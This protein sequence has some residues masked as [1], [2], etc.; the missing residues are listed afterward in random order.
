M[1]FDTLPFLIFAGITYIVWRT[2]LGPVTVLCGASILFYLVAGFGDAL[3]IASVVLTN[4]FFSFYVRGRAWVLTTVVALNLANLAYFKYSAFI[5]AGIAGIDGFTGG[6][7]I[8]LGISFYTFQLIA[9]Q[10][11]IAGGRCEQEPN[12]LRFAL[13]VIFFT[14]LIAG[15]IVRAST[16]LPQIRRQWEAQQRRR[17]I[18]S[19]G[20]GLCALGLF[21]KVILSDSL[22]PLVDQ[23]FSLGPA[24]TASAWIGAWLFAFQ[25][26]F[27]FSGYCDIAMGIAYLLGYRLPLNFRQ[28]YLATNPR[29]FWRCWHITLSSWIRDYLY[30]PLG[31]SREGGR[32]RKAVVLI[33]VMSLAGLWHGAGWVFVVWGAFWGV[34]IVLWNTVRAWL[35]NIPVLRWGVN[36]TVVVVLWVFFRSPDITF[37]AAYIFAMFGGDAGGTASFVGG[38]VPLVLLGC[39]VLMGLHYG[40]AKM[41]SPRFLRRMR[42]ADLPMVHGLLIGLIAIMLILPKA[43]SNPFIYFTF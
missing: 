22:A 7:L 21:K 20:L 15:P 31:G 14:Q 27:D 40:E 25:I 42:H 18:V 26:Y 33:L 5:L 36:L 9:Y 28:P 34:Y 43:V 24:D 37:A 1:S 32:I 3:L 2:P 4:F 29:A 8:P 16:M 39:A 30:I 11:D 12:F 38:E 6:I 17:N 10:V 35:P 41:Y 19:I 23:A 13:F